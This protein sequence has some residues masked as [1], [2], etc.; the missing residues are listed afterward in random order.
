LKK[1]GDALLILSPA[2]MKNIFSLDTL[3]AKVKTWYR[4]KYIPPPDND[5]DSPIAIISGG[6][7]KQPFLAKALGQICKFWL[8]HWQWI[9]VF[10]IAIASLIVAMLALRES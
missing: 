2:Y 1:E 10:L 3:S 8:N 4:G 5:P 9:L 6:H 7:Y